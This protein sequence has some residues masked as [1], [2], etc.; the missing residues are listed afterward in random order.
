MTDEL[1]E[2][3]ELVKSN[4]GFGVSY[5]HLADT[6]CAAVHLADAYLAANPADSD[7]ALL[8][9]EER[10]QAENPATEKRRRI[11]YQDIVYHVCNALDRRFGGVT[12]CGT[13]ADPSTEVQEKINRLVLTPLDPSGGE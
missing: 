10:M 2:A 3:A 8:K 1:R 12:R 7:V 9:N 11:Y 6:I 13:W 4:V 5:P